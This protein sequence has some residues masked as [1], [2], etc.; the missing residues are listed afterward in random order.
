MPRSTADI[1]SISIASGLRESSKKEE[2]AYD[3]PAHFHEYVFHHT[4]GTFHWE[5]YE[6]ILDG[7]NNPEGDSNPLLVLAPRDHAKSTIGE[8]FL[9]WCI[10]KNPLELCQIVCS[11]MP[12]ARKRLTKVASA[13]RDSERYKDLFGTLFPND[14]DYEWS[15]DAIEVKRDRSQVWSQGKA[16]RD[17]TVAALGIT[18]TV[19]GGRATLQVYD[20]IVSSENSRSP[21]LRSSV[22][23]KFWMAFNPMLL[24]KG[25]QIFFGTRYHYSDFYSEIVPIFDKERLYTALYPK[26]ET[27]EFLE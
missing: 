22:R 25:Q 12:L 8:A 5:I 11:V 27:E 19:E 4:L 21:I 3:H 9:L 20:D 15:R 10:G 2:Q 14:P 1:S 7:Y 6:R 23:E 18:T 17:P 26:E 13:I 16:E 24:P